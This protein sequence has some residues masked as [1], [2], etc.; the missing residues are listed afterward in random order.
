MTPPAG[1]Y[2]FALVSKLLSTCVSR[3]QATCDARYVKQII[4]ELGHMKHLADDPFAGLGYLVLI[5][6]NE[7]EKLACG[8]A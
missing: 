5:G 4:E 3:D 1:L 2:R 8:R 7:L 6:T